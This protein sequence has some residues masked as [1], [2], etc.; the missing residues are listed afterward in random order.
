MPFITFE[1]MFTHIFYNLCLSRSFFRHV[2]AY[3]TFLYNVVVV[4]NIYNFD[5]SP[6]A[7]VRF[8]HIGVVVI[9]RVGRGWDREKVFSLYTSRL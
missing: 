6:R 7:F 9:G 2:L 3:G 5:L 8:A 1:V 4:V